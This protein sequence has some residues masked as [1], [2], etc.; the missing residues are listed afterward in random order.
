MTRPVWT[1]SLVR[2]LHKFAFR[3]LKRSVD[4]NEDFSALHAATLRHQAS[5]LAQSVHHVLHQ[6]AHLS[7]AY[8]PQKVTL[9]GHSMGGIAARLALEELSG[10][11]DVILTMST[12]H[13]LPPVTLEL[14]MDRIWRTLSRQ[15]H[16]ATSPLLFSICGGTADT[17]IASDACVIP[18]DNFG[19]DNGLTI[20]TTG[21]P[22]VWTS[23]EHQAMVWC[24]QVRWR[25]ART[26]LDMTA[27]KNRQEKLAVAEEWLLGQQPT[28]G[29]S[30]D[31]ATRI[32]VTS[33]S[34]SVRFSNA[35]SDSSAAIRWCK[36][37][38]DCRY[39]RGETTILPTPMNAEA[40]F[41]L[42][43]EGV[44]PEEEMTVIDV[45]LDEAVGW[46]EIAD[47]AGLVTAGAAAIYKAK[48]GTWLNTQDSRQSHVAIDFDG[49]S[50]S[51]LLVH[52]LDVQT[53]SCSGTLNTA[54]A[55]VSG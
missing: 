29:S 35:A 4:Y 31:R 49:A 53:G 28:I 11:V 7:E 9:V 54:P 10:L 32:P 12:P 47:E 21:M 46:L 1:S 34:M 42:P 3:W 6:Y 13:A 30:H 45:K 8:R 23:V 33:T 48:S 51:S 36:A 20:F 19:T 18:S 40:P 27:K 52:R 43:G 38:S 41:P 17:Q 5:F 44:K 55:D 25:V 2:V 50:S 39:I 15:T 37:E 22:G 14:D 24:H 26:L 16:N